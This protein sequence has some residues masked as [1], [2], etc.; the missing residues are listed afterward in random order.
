MVLEEAYGVGV[1]ERGFDCHD[2]FELVS[3]AEREEVNAHVVFVGVGAA[4]AGAERKF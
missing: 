4:G 2:V 3:D 1:F